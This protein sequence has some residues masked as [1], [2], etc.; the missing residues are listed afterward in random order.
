MN[1]TIN[2]TIK[3]TKKTILSIFDSLLE[4]IADSILVLSAIQSE[5]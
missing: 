4:I 1:D 3:D 2:N 5:A